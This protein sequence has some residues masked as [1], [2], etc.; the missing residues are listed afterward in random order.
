MS[1]L[2]PVC[3]LSDNHKFSSLIAFQENIRTKNQI[4]LGIRIIS[5]FVRTVFLVQRQQRVLY[6]QTPLQVFI[7]LFSIC[8]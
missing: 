5:C 3:F 6:I 8:L 2:L 7:R 4:N 1:T